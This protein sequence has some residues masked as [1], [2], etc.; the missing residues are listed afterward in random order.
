MKT[1]NPH[2][3]DGTT[4]YLIQAFARVGKTSAIQLSSDPLHQDPRESN[5]STTNRSAA[6]REA[7]HDD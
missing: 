2:C 1:K 6:S 7:S 5:E 4:S 3:L